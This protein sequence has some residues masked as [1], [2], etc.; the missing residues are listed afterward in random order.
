[1]SAQSLSPSPHDGGAAA[2]ARHYAAIFAISFAALL[3]E[4]SYTR[5][6]SFKL[7]YYY[8][9]LVIGLAL[10]GLGAGGVL[11]AISTRL[12]RADMD[13]LLAGGCLAAAVLAGSG[14]LVVG[15]IPID[16]RVIW[17]GQ[18]IGAGIAALLAICMVPFATFLAVGI[19]V[20]SLLG[21][22]AHR[23][24][25]MYC[26]DLAGGGLACAVVV[27]MLGT[28]GP[29]GAVFAAAALLALT[30]AAL[31]YHAGTDH[32]ARKL[33]HAST[34][35]AGVLT[36]AVFTH[37]LLPAMRTDATKTITRDT[38]ILFSQWSPVFR[39][40]V[41]LVPFTTEDDDRRI[42]H[43]DGLWGSGLHRY[44]GNPASL[45]R[46]DDNPR[47]LPFRVLG[48]PPSQV[49]IIGAAGGNEIL[50]SLHFDAAHIDAVELNPVTVSLLTD[51]FAD[52]TGHLADN[53]KVSLTVDDGRSYLARNDQRYD[54]I[55]FVAPDSYS[56]L[57][58]AASSAFVLTESYLY[59][60]EMVE[61]SL[62]HLAP[63]GII[64]MQFGEFSYDAKPNRT[65]R[66]VATAREALRR[67][68]IEDPDRH[69]LVASSHEILDLSTV[70]IK[71]T[72]FDDDEIASF[73]ATVPELHKTTARYVPGHDLDHGP[74]NQLLA[75]GDDEVGPW[76]ERYR[77]DVSP[78]TDDAPFF[79]H[80]ARFRT[81]FAEFFESLSGIDTED[82]IGEKILLLLLALSAALAAV[83]LLLPF[84]V[85][86]SEWRRLPAKLTSAVYFSALGLGFMLF[87]VC[88]IQKLTLFL[89]YPTYSLTVTLMSLLVF[90]GL[91]S[92]AAGT[93]DAGG[94]RA[95]TVLFA[96][97]TA[98]VVFYEIGLTP[99]THALFALPLAARVPIAIVLL[100]P[101]GL[102]LGAFM[103]LGLSRIS[104]LT[105]HADEYVA[106][107]WAVN[108]F[109]SVI[110]SVLTT[111]L[112]MSF[113]FSVVLLLA[114]GAYAIAYAAFLSMPRSA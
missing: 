110:G 31:F 20:A 13:R 87:E 3:V 74:V 50:A 86:H 92:L 91:G 12:K 69:I 73:L 112:S 43:H 41:T 21:R 38:P 2:P 5:L 80:F 102:C 28:V 23:V 90:T 35:L 84:V 93:Y 82:A 75:L 89:G 19:M 52:W 22:N 67:L 60:V 34:A 56:A 77:Y 96:V 7:F 78:V 113:G 101:L 46:F 88:L 27:P 11:V 57:N 83:F 108:G 45:T 4:I 48:N 100:A 30:A 103:P 66:Y 15:E 37:H 64:C 70:L 97:V 24:A 99:V 55:F 53:P 98:L 62:K 105:E 25:P 95:M 68:G 54:L 94:S 44:D 40:D 59:T 33:G 111:I 61:E 49:L 81:V 39:I 29:P 71:A 42:T 109:F 72:P 10:L 17:S 63:D 65:T 1:V 9:Y 47:A 18:A 114:L 79:W 6:I 16:T 26:A 32:H 104:T 76:L 8:T 106:W 14:Y 58:A 85:L 51:A 36:L 107:G